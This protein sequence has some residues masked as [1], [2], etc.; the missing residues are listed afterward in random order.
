MRWT[1]FL[2][3]LLFSIALFVG[4]ICLIS[5]K[6]KEAVPTFPITEEKAFVIIIPS[7]NNE[8]YVEKNLRS[9]FSQDYENYRVLYIDD[10]SSD[11]TLKK[12]TQLLR[13]LDTKKRTV[14]I[15]NERNLGALANIYN[16]VHSCADSEIVVL[17]DGDDF[18]AH[19]QVLNRLNTAYANPD[20]WLTYGNYLDYPAFKQNPLICK[21]LEK[22]VVK[23]NRFRK[24][25]W[26][27]THLR[28]FYATLFKQIQIE[29]LF[30]EGRFF[31]MGSDLALLYPML[32]M[33]KD[34]IQFIDEVLYLYN[35]ENPIS[36]HKINFAFQNQCANE[37]RQRPAYNTLKRLP[38]T[39]P[40]SSQTADLL[41]FSQDR[42]LELFALLESIERYVK[43]LEKI[44]VL[45]TTTHPE[46]DPAY[47]EIKIRF[48]HVQFVK[49]NG[50]KSF[51]PLCSKILFESSL[52]K[53]PFI[54]FA[55]D[56]MV[57]KDQINISEGIKLLD[58]SGAYGLYLSYHPEL[59]Y[60]ISLQR[61]QRVPPATPLAGLSS[62]ETPFAWQFSSGQD[63]WN[64]PCNF[65]FTLYRKKDLQD[66][67][68][69]LS[70]DSPHTLLEKW[71]LSSPLDRIGLF[72]GEAK[73]IQ[74]SEH[75]KNS[76]EIFESGLKIDLGPLFRTTSI[77]QQLE[78]NLPFTTRE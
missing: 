30:Y 40:P 26:V 69:K 54:L 53:S 36:D 19:E 42:P 76:L 77:S 44:T 33:G 41:I 35:R 7:Y 27:T 55:T 38:R 3:L 68:T 78:V 50:P 34:H 57:F 1:K 9:I 66:P 32:E 37:I 28:S 21:E 75:R 46:Y 17:V 4:R 62:G 20:I 25:P 29:D 63:D 61:H 47:L 8:K 5:G 22:K 74:L 14:L 39:L 52:E 73:A 23:K 6:N 60:C 11:K 49:E 65:N 48:P 10:N 31:P 24:S 2:L 12:A 59:E 58:R 13:E 51:K 70:Y 56:R 71:N 64:N 16:A 67:F 72:Y 45:Y 18:L 43:G 15:H